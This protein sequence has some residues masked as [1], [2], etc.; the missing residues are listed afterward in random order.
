MH[1]APQQPRLP[2]LT[3]TVHLL[4][5]PPLP[6]LL[7]S[8]A[9]FASG[10]LY[11]PS[12]AADAFG[13]SASFLHWDASTSSPVL[14]EA[15][16]WVAGLS[17]ESGAGN[18]LGVAYAL[19][20]LAAAH[21][22][23]G[24][25]QAAPLLLAQLATFVQRTLLALKPD[26]RGKAV[27]LTDPA[28]RGVRASLFWGPGMPNFTY[29]VQPCWDEARASTTWRSY[30]Y[31][32]PVATLLAAYRI[33]RELPGLASASAALAAA[34]GGALDAP[35]A[36]GAYLAAAS[37]VHSAMGAL[38]GYNQFGLMVGSVYGE[39]MDALAQEAGAAG[40]EA[41]WATRAAAAS[42]LQANRTALF[43]VPDF[44][45]GSEMPWD[46]TGQEEIFA[47]T[48]RFA[49]QPGFERALRTANLTLSAVLAYTPLCPHALY[50]GSARRYF[51]FLVYGDPAMNR[52][53][54]RALHHYGAG[55]N[56]IVLAAAAA[57]LPNETYYARAAFAASWAPLL[58]ID[59]QSGAPSMGFHG[60]PGAL[61][62]DGYSGDWGQ[63]MYGGAA[64]WGC[65]VSALPELAGGL[66]GLGCDVQQ[67]GGS[68]AYTLTPYDPLRA[69]LYL[70]P[71]GLQV[72]LRTGAWAQGVWDVAAR[73][74]TLGIA[75]AGAA[76]LYYDFLQ[77]VLGAPALEG[78]A[79]QPAQNARI[80]APTGALMVR[81]AWVLPQS[82]ESVVVCWD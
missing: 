52:G 28:T 63:N 17:D 58:A 20:G 7:L 6:A 19:P 78:A 68:G 60:D 10:S 3:L 38:G 56:G 70:G 14:Q 36:W 71:V 31:P 65:G 24:A 53:T 5:L 27:G 72:T 69:R 2:P 32:H 81:G 50:S 22:P 34:S 30:N 29:S 80:C 73:T 51:D 42:A 18:A 62:W 35:G 1:L 47:F 45:Y 9:R 43:L 40:A 66:A 4:L 21:A 44:P 37:D 13:R 46:S 74:L 61:R 64:T 57:L 11:L 77:L 55:L 26:A 12:T 59:A 15:R 41:Q 67:Q 39:L 75:G 79:A 76:P 33:T 16:A 8:F 82:T 23:A 49:A 25:A 48:R 54:E